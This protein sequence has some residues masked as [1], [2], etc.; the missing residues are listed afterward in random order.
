ML[1]PY[2]SRASSGLQPPL[3][4]MAI[5]GLIGFTLL[6]LLAQVGGV[7]RLAYPAGTFVVG[8][9]LYQRYPVLYVGF[10]W[11]VA[12]LTPL[13][14][15]LVDLQSGWV[16]PSPI[17]LAPFLVILISGMTFLQELPRAY[18]QA[19][20]PFI[21]SAI[22]I[23]Y[24]L[25]V[26]LVKN[27]PTGVVVPL[28]NWLAPLLLGFFLYANWRDYPAYRQNLQRVF[29]WGTLVTG[30]YGI[31]QYLTAP[32]WDGAWLTNTGLLTFGTPEPLGIRVFSTMNSPG[33]FATV[34]MAGLMLLL[35]ST[36]SLRF[37]A[38][39]AGYLAFL[40]SLVRSAWLSWVVAVVTFLPS[41]KTKFQIRFIVTALIMMILVLPLVNLQPFSD[42]IA[43]RIETLFNT[44]E[45]VSYNERME[46]YADLLTQGLLEIPGNGFGFV[47]ANDT[48]GSNDSGVLTLLFTLGWFG[49]IPYLGGILLLFLKLFQS[50]AIRIDPVATAARAIALGTFAQMGL[51]NPML[52]LSGMV[53]WGFLGMALAAQQYH[54]ET[55]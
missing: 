43:P 46:G 55:S 41:L 21:L 2:N 52:A 9:L 14:R 17:L 47:L 5:L 32:A 36:S 18:R 29:L 11:W 44:R 23:F 35:S 33:P 40:L 19:G 37:A 51:G 31:F 4:W 6:C 38:S 54:T 3:A 22:A 45:D 34:M 49:T 10:C 25:L 53:F 20:F 39:G 8:L 12:F 16:D 13:V 28:L 27:S 48:L 50:T 15:R 24:G 42:A 7:L 26:G 1:H 30:G